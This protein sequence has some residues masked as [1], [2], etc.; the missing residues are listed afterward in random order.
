LETCR[1]IYLIKRKYLCR[2][3]QKINVHPQNKLIHVET[4]EIKSTCAHDEAIFP[5]FLTL[6][7]IL[8]EM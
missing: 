8:M 6:E 7:W 4:G 1:Y 2:E 5:D 3:N